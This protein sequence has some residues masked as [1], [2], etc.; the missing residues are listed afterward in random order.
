MNKNQLLDMM[1]SIRDQY[2]MEAIESRDQTGRKSHLRVHRIGLL[3]AVI[4]A[5][6]LLAGCVAV[7]LRLQDL[8]IGKE[9]H[10]QSFDEKGRAIEPTEKTWEVLNFSGIAGSPEQKASAQW[11]EFTESY[12]LD[13]ALT[14]NETD[15]PDI[16]NNYEYTYGCYTQEM[17]RKLDEIIS[18]N[19]LQLLEDDIPI[20]RWHS[21]IAMEALGKTSLL[22]EGA[23][24]QMGPASGFLFAP[25]NFKME[26]DLTLTGDNPAWGKRVGVTELFAHKGYMPYD[27]Y[28]SVNL[29]AIRQWNY[30]TSEGVSLLMAM[31]DTGECIIVCQLDSGILM[32]DISGNTTGTRYPEPDQVPG[33]EAMEA[34]AEVLDF[35]LDYAPFDVAAIRPKLEEADKAYEEAHTFEPE[36]YGTYGDYLLGYDYGWQPGQQYVFYDLNGDGTKE[37]LLGTDG[38]CNTWLTQ[39][40]GQVE[41]HFGWQF[42]PCEDGSAE[43][44]ESMDF[45]SFCRYRY[46][47]L[48]EV[49]AEVEDYSEYLEIEYRG[50]QW[51]KCDEPT[52]LDENYQVITQEEANAI[53]AEHP[54]VKLDWIPVEDFP[55]DEQ[56]LTLGQ[57]LQSQPKPSREEL[58]KI[59]AD[60]MRHLS[61]VDESFFYTHYR[62]MDVNGDGTEELLLSGDGEHFWTMYSYRYG[63]LRPFFNSDFFLCENGILERVSIYH[64]WQWET[65]VSGWETE[66][67]IFYQIGENMERETLAYAGYNKATASWQSD[68]DGTPMGTEEAEA[69]LAKYPR[70][71]QGMHPISELIG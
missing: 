10:V 50:G 18:E 22:R 53:R 9:T 21:D 70:V 20:Q 30:T 14:T 63:K 59:Y 25:Y 56:G 64:Q 71:D 38:F 65:A 57:Y 67:H 5:L 27:G 12:D 43:I 15:N 19:H 62:F 23:A 51:R 2:V 32:V 6:M 24:A 44:Y 17:V 39:K 11:Y 42:L 33:K 13:H 34:F 54:A 52:A 66:E 35:S 28:W 47:P 46:L 48:A 1:N 4:A 45:D 7:Y 37:L 31:S 26:Y 58:R 8:S 41:E 16:P 3:A 55:M 69:I 40:N 29:D 49:V 61:E 60:H 36:V 68:R